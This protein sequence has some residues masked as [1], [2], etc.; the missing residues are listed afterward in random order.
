MCIR[1]RVQAAAADPEVTG[2]AQEAAVA[3]ELRR[4][5]RT[6]CKAAGKVKTDRQADRQT[7]SQTYIWGDIQMPQ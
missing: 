5:H 3:A 1:D 2:A 4:Y 6:T 7:D